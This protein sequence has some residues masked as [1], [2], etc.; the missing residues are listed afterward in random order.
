MNHSWFKH[1]SRSLP[2]NDLSALQAHVHSG[3]SL[4]CPPTP[5]LSNS[6][7]PSF[8]SKHSKHIGPLNTSII[9]SSKLGEQ[10]GAPTFSGSFSGCGSGF[11]I[12][13][14][15]CSF[16]I[17]LAP[18]AASDTEPI[19]PLRS[20]IS[21]KG[22]SEHP[23]DTRTEF[24]FRPNPTPEVLP[25]FRPATVDKGKIGGADIPCAVEKQESTSYQ[26]T[27][28]SLLISFVNTAN[29]LPY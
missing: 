6:L 15:S 28:G 27:S 16:W 20:L 10:S 25:A 18:R 8:S 24:F 1:S 19:C 3:C 26:T 29:R 17:H 4:F 2:L 7:S 14:Q 21:T 9:N 11:G 13:T 5:S 23:R 12:E 22:L